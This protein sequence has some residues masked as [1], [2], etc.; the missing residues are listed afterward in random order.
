MNK[1]PTKR[2]DPKLKSDEERELVDVLQHRIV[3]QDMA[4]EILV[5]A[6]EMHRS[7]L[8]SPERTV[9]NL[10]FLG[11]TGVGKTL[12]FEAMAEALFGTKRAL[13]KV[14][15]AEFQH[16]HEISKLLGSPPGYLGHKDTKPYLTQENMDEYHTK[17]LKLTLLLF[18]EFEKAND[19]L[20]NLLLGITDK[21]TCTLGDNRRTD[22][23]NCIVGMTG[24]LGSREIQA[25]VQGGLGFAGSAAKVRKDLDKEIDQAAKE[26]AKRRFNAEFLNRIDEIVVFHS[27]DEKQL[28]QV[29]D[30]EL[31]EVQRLVLGVKNH[32]QFVLDYTQAAKDLIL[33]KGTDI[34][35][36]ARPLKRIIDKYITKRLARF[37]NTEQIN[38]GDMVVVDVETDDSLKFTR[39]AEGVILQ[40]DV[41][42]EDEADK[43]LE[44]AR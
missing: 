3:G 34:K 24:N 29:V 42:A 40:S 4:I 41:E 36:G 27:L 28:R 11:P 39:V 15:C 14:D 8:T 16:S 18:D 33:S 7:G 26:A 1:K 38:M 19:A 2:L 22:F 12:V 21:A 17:E 43:A 10:I 31:E 5:D 32:R 44:A 13:K 6:Y 9:S 20:W 37:L 25:L 23:S 30:I 35:N